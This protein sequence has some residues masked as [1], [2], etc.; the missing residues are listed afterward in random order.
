MIMI[1]FKFS[2]ISEVEVHLLIMNNESTCTYSS[3]YFLYHISMLC[4]V[5]HVSELSE[6]L[7]DCPCQDGTKEVCQYIFK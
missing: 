5:R 2:V 7:S 3:I 1:L 4:D 6:L